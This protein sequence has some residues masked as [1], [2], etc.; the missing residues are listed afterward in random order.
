[1]LFEQNRKKRPW[2][3]Q[4]KG[5]PRFEKSAFKKFFFANQSGKIGCEKWS[6]LNFNCI[7]QAK[8]KWWQKPKWSQNILRPIYRRRNRQSVLWTCYS[9]LYIFSLLIYGNQY[10]MQFNFISNPKK[11]NFINL[12]NLLNFLPDR[13]ADHFSWCKNLYLSLLSKTYKI[14]IFKGLKSLKEIY[15]AFPIGEQKFNQ[16]KQDGKTTLRRSGFC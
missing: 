4:L 13:L 1:M 5:F 2:K 12:S 15:A 6:R 10:F 8:S 9:C 14:H 16:K 7:D 3:T 11:G